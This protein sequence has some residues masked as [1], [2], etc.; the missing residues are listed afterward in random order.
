MKL[1]ENEEFREIPNRTSKPPGCTQKEGAHV[2]RIVWGAFHPSKGG[3]LEQARWLQEDVFNLPEQIRYFC[4]SATKV[5]DTFGLADLLSPAASEP[6]CGS[7][8]SLRC[9]EEASKERE[10]R[11]RKLHAPG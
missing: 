6:R 10:E 11:T 2:A 7:G 4:G 5:E 8:C 1:K 3:L 9:A